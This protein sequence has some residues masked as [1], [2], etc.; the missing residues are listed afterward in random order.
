MSTSK[1]DFAKGSSRKGCE[2]QVFEESIFVVPFMGCVFL[3]DEALG[4]GD[5]G[6]AE[7]SFNKL[8]VK[9]VLNT[10]PDGCGR[11]V[12][13]DGVCESFR[14]RGSVA[15]EFSC[16]TLFQARFVAGQKIGD[17]F[18]LWAEQE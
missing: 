3:G 15:V 8:D 10:L 4:F 7:C 1:T 2:V 18:V 12:E 14:E 16:K 11:R 13:I 9:G 17:L 6:F 5:F